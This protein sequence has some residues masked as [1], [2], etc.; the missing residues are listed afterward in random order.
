MTS[1]GMEI[2]LETQA[3][4]SI[5][6]DSFMTWEYKQRRTNLQVA[7][8]K[9]FFSILVTM[10]CCPFAAFAPAQ[11]GYIGNLTPSQTIAYGTKSVT[12][13][14]QIDTLDNGPVLGEGSL[15]YYVGV[16]LNWADG[17][18]DYYQQTPILDTGDFNCIFDTSNIPV[19]NSPYTISF[20]FPNILL[21]ND[22]T[23]TLTVTPL[24]VVLT[25]ARA[26]DGTATAVS[27]ILSVSNVVPGDVVYV[28]SGSAT[29]G[30]TNAGVEAITDFTGLTL[31]GPSA[32]NYT[33]AGA[34]GSV[35]I[36]SSVSNLIVQT[37]PPTGVG[38]LSATLN[39]TINPQG[40]DAIGYFEYGTDTNY[41]S[42]TETIA[43]GNV[44]T[45]E[46]FSETITNLAVNTMYHYQAVA[47]TG[48]VYSYGADQTVTTEPSLLALANLCNDVYSD[49]TLTSGPGGYV[50]PPAYKYFGNF[51]N[52]LQTQPPTGLNLNLYLSPDKTQ[53]VI[54]FRGTV[55]SAVS[56]FI[57]WYNVCA[58]AGFLAQPPTPSASFANYSYE[59][60]LFVIKIQNLYSNANI[61]LTGHSLGG[62]LAQL[63]GQASGL[64]TISFNAP[65]GAAFTNSLSTALFA[66]Y[67][68]TL[69]A[70]NANI[71][72]RLEDDIVSAAGTNFPG[73]TT[74]ASPAIDLISLGLFLDHPPTTVVD[75]VDALP[76]L[77]DVHNIETVISQIANNATQLAGFQ[78]PNYLLVFSQSLVTAT[79][80]TQNAQNSTS[81]A[82]NAAVTAATG[83][84]LNPDQQAGGT[85]YIL[86]ENIGSPGISSLI[87]PVI[88]GV[89]SYLIRSDP[90][91]SWSSFQSTQPG[92]QVSFGAGANNIEFVPMDSDGN[93]FNL[94][95][96]SLGLN[97]T[98]SG[99]FAGTLMQSNT[100]PSFPP[101][102]QI[103]QAGNQ[104]ILGW[105]TNNPI[106][107]ALFTATSLVAPIN[108]VPV[109]N[110]PAIITNQFVVTVTMPEGS[111]FFRLQQ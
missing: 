87:L 60:A 7:V 76:Y 26:Y 21:Q 97:F 37:L 39:G 70:Q 62:A 51:Q 12:L 42:V 15:G 2:H 1:V 5:S 59:S 95:G 34:S 91:G 109:T 50:G 68:P 11:Y 69:T 45:N 41:G 29:L 75:E 110:T 13:S 105:T 23:T 104:L 77:H 82:F 43:V 4:T 93:P 19:T 84:V 65:G 25:G 72:Y 85:D 90:D 78:G 52:Y 9:R 103:K 74:I 89:T 107:L 61:T 86:S 18:G 102:L 71:N 46:P 73:V 27:T 58:D 47:V 3:I 30:N 92:T 83:V 64:T 108:W 38:N 98:S 10:L 31:G 101:T 16:G 79:S 88:S 28:S 67:W 63:V 22:N 6:I 36:T 100:V 40:T 96:L 111:R 49:D 54:A 48:G 32:T 81:Y 80:F 56:P 44:S 33:L 24:P 8:K 106:S 53:A 66:G 20:S 57:S 35:T 99:S 14:G 17:L 94:A 55:L